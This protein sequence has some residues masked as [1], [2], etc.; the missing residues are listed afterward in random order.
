MDPDNNRNA[1]PTSEDDLPLPPQLHQDRTVYEQK[2][3]FIVRPSAAHW[4]GCSAFD[5]VH[6]K[7]LNLFS[8]T[9][10]YVKKSMERHTLCHLR[11]SN[12]HKQVRSCCTRSVNVPDC[13]C[14]YSISRLLAKSS[15]QS[16]RAYRICIDCERMA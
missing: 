10:A 11:Y 4:Q 7:T 5:V 1:P 3:D 12:T 15:R 13:D 6:H 2:C 14:D 9:N 8:F 16:V